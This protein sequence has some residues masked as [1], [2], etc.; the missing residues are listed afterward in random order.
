MTRR[1]G[2]L[3]PKS[4]ARAERWLRQ[5]ARRIVARTH[6]EKIVLFGSYA[7]GHPGP[8]SD[9]DLLVV[10]DKPRDRFKRYRLVENAI[11]G[12]LWPLDIL[13][14]SQDEIAARLRLGDSF[15][16]GILDRGEV[17]HES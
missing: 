5:A 7:Y 16:G 15:I 9:M 1:R 8:D 12:H 2:R 13:V 10:L 6:P 3:P 17:L 11:G 4:R 14:R